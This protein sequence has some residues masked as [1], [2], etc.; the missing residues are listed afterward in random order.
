MFF[1]ESVETGKKFM[2]KYR[3]FQCFLPF[4]SN[5]INGKFEKS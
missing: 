3:F 2:R 5:S 1:L 4:L